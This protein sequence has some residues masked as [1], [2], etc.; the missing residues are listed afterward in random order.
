LA[1]SIADWQ[2]SEVDTDVVKAVIE[3][4]D[5]IVV[6]GVDDWDD[7]ESDVVVDEVDWLVVVGRLT[8]VVEEVE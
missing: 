5:N 7:V 8:E 3:E 6:T 4:A 1:I 2:S